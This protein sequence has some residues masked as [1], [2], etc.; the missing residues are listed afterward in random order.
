M[1]FVRPRAPAPVA[2]DDSWKAQGFINLY[3]SAKDGS[4]RKIGFVALKQSRAT[5][6]QLIEWLEKDPAN[7]ESLKS[8]LIIEYNSA[9]AVQTDSLDL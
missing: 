7:I 9:I 2:Q 5:D 1:A 3:L 8:K 4:R 6:A